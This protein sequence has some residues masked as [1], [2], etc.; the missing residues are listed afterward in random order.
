MKARAWLCMLFIC[1]ISFTGFS[2]TTDLT[3]DSDAVTISTYNVEGNTVAAIVVIKSDLKAS[4]S[5]DFVFSTNIALKSNLVNFNTKTAFDYLL[6]EQ[7]KT[8][9]IN[10]NKESVIEKSPDLKNNKNYL[11][12]RNARDGLTC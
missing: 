1:M 9:L 7:M 8:Q 3:K 11:S 5:N 2:T 10:Y 6:I 4:E 12:S